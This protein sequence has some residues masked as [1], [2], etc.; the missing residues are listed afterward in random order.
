MEVEILVDEH[1]PLLLF[2]TPERF[3]DDFLCQAAQ[4]TSLGLLWFC[5]RK[6]CGLHKLCRRQGRD[7][8]APWRGGGDQFSRDQA[9]SM[10]E[11]GEALG[12]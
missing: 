11:P 4:G 1:E 9:S 12:S 3:V 10:S 5:F 2:V 6:C 8:K 7:D